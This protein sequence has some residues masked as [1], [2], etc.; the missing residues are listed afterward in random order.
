M[1]RKIAEL[2]CDVVKELSVSIVHKLHGWY[3]DRFISI[4]YRG[5]DASPTR[6]Y[7]VRTMNQA[8][9]F[10]AMIYADAVFYDQNAQV[11]ERN[12]DME[13]ALGD[14]KEINIPSMPKI[15]GI[16]TFAMSSWIGKQDDAY[17]I[18]IQL[19]PRKNKTSTK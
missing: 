5:R 19:F 11:P 1:N 17:I 3:P 7:L 18:P 9:K 16:L 8:L 4:Q 13:A 14:P 12:D 15:K 6:K 10:L 2:M